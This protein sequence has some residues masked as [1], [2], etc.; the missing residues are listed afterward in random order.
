MFGMISSVSALSVLETGWLVVGGL[1]A[2]AAL[3]AFIKFEFER[4]RCANLMNLKR[5]ERF[6]A[7]WMP[8]NSWRLS[9]KLRQMKRVDEAESVAFYICLW[10]LISTGLFVEDFEVLSI[11]DWTVV[12]FLVSA[13]TYWLVKALRRKTLSQF[14]CPEFHFLMPTRLDGPQL[15][16][17][18]TRPTRSEFRETAVRLLFDAVLWLLVCI[19][20]LILLRS[21]PRVWLLA[22]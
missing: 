11:G 15:R 12:L 2:L 8:P 3:S 14:F 16:E 20:L 13:V 10:L 1:L 18:L 4:T 7:F 9:K 19:V 17:A 6:R 22:H 21:Y 5:R